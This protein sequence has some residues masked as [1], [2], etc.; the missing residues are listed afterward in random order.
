VRV[1]RALDG[2]ELPGSPALLDGAAELVRLLDGF[3]DIAT[4]RPAAEAAV[5]VLA[6]RLEVG[7]TLKARSH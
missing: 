1:R 3:A 2:A 5:R 4:L 7:G 6:A